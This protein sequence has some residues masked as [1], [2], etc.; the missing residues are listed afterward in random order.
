MNLGRMSPAQLLALRDATRAEAARRSLR[1]FVR[2][3]WHVL[4]PTRPLLWSWHIEVVA[5]HVQALLKELVR[6]RRDPTYRMQ[7]QDLLINVPPRSMKTLVCG[8]FAPAWIWLDDPS[9]K[10]RYMSGN[11]RVVSQA[12]RASRDLIASDWY[13]RTFQPEW[14]VRGDI[15]AVGLYTNTAR[16]ERHSSTFDARVT[17]E[18]TDVIFIDDPVDASDANSDAVRE[19]VNARYDE[20]IANRVND[21]LRC[22]RVGIMQRLHE[23]DWSGHVLSAEGSTWRHLKI[24]M[25]YEA[26][27]PCPCRDCV[28]GET[29]FGWSDPRTTPGE[30]LHPE[31]FPP[32][33]VKAEKTRLGSYGYA[34]QHQQRPSAATGG[35]FKKA[36]WRFWKPDGTGADVSPRPEGCYEGPARPVPDRF[37][38]VVISLDANF[39]GVQAKGNDPVVFVVVGCKGADRFVLDRV[40]LFVGFTETLAAF[41]LL[42]KKFPKAYRKLVEE[43][44]NGAAIIESLQAEIGGIIPIDPEGGKQA[45]ASAVAPQVESGNVYLPDGAPWLD[46]WVDEF[47]TFPKGT[48]DDQVDALSQALLELLTSDSAARLRSLATR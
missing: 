20:A 33:V 37:D 8:V 47:A 18:G 46:E 12:S 44:A 22:A 41:R 27:N 45:R 10:I 38:R 6:A 34:G 26:R 15:D 16:G 32:E 35:T 28:A 14:S 43:K 4:E 3:A 13:Q 9:L 48:H 40:R 23:Q 42:V 21:P 7:V 5:D 39:K 25:E 36:W 17:G 30:V 11:P 19:H 24:P 31:R 2:Q 29:V 1:E